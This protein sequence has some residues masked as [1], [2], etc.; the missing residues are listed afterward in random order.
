MLTPMLS[1]LPPV[2][3]NRGNVEEDVRATNPFAVC[4]MRGMDRLRRISR[5]AGV[6]WLIA[7]LG[8]VQTLATAEGWVFHTWAVSW[9][10]YAP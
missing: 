2:L 3:G 8:I 1:P 5:R 4:R 10:V 7:V 6:G 9:A